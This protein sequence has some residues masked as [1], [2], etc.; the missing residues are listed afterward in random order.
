MF[1]A[2]DYTYDHRRLFRFDGKRFAE[3]AQPFRYV[4]IEGTTTAPLALTSERES[5]DRKPDAKHVL[6]TLPQRRRSRSC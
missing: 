1:G 4:G 2:T 6:A 5:G 3:V